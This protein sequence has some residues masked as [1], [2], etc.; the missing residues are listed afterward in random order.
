MEATDFHLNKLKKP[1]SMHVQAQLENSL[2]HRLACG[3]Q[4]LQGTYFYDLLSALLIAC[5]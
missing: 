1:L 2:L 4:A 3:H 5:L